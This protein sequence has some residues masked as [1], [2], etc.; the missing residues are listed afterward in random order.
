MSTFEVMSR[1]S[2]VAPRTVW[3]VG[4]NVLALVATLFMLRQA[5]Q[6]VSWILISL[7]LALA[8]EPILQFLQRQKVRRGWAIFGTY[9]GAIALVVVLASTFIP[10]VGEQAQALGRQAPDL[11]DR[12]TEHRWV[13]WADRQFGI[14]QRVKTELGSRAGLVAAP[15]FGFVKGVVGALAAGL[16]IRSLTIFMSVYGGRLFAGALQWLEPGDRPRII[17]L[18]R[19]MTTTVGG[20]AIG[21]FLVSLLGGVVTAVSLALL[22]VPY[23]LPLGLAMALLGVLPWIGSA[24]GAVLVV[25]T[26]F[27]TTGS[28]QGL[29]ALAIFLVYQQ[30]ENRITPLVQGRTI[31]MNPLLIALV[32]L[33]GTAL[34]GVLGAVLSIPVA[35]AIQVVL[36]DVLAERQRRW[37]RGR[38][39]EEQLNLPGL[40]P[41]QREAH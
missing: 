31:R 29:I 36:Q 14:I 19:K 40:E 6:V 9:V 5:G 24:L 20:Y 27:A 7:V 32:M 34:W 38:A 33:I 30:L 39:V 22:G 11:L 15:V 12:L 8:V 10:M 41:S 25:G 16:T 4:L 13:A 3:V 35:G 18:S 37:T 21:T 1:R 17:R 26:T 2:Q 28:R 23:F